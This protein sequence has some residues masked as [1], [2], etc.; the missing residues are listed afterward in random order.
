VKRPSLIFLLFVAAAWRLAAA[1]FHVSAAA[2]LTDALQE[3]AASYESKEGDKPVFNFGASSVLARQ[4]AE[5]APAD[6]FISADE[7]KMDQLE[8]KSLV[9]TGTRKSLL[10]NSLVIVVEQNSKLALNSPQDLTKLKRLALAETKTVPAGIYARKYLENLGLWKEVSGKI[11]P[12]ENVR[13]ALSAVESGNV[14][15]GIVYKTDAAISKTTKVAYE[16]PRKDLPEIS[17]AFAV[18]NTGKQS[19][20][21][22]RFL[23]YLASDKSLKV[24]EKYGFIINK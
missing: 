19:G 5:G 15:A 9:K 1:D 24:F 6:L 10:S 8:K 11:I 13:A 14:D 4:I 22:Q 3:L 18:M 7:E 16:V 21:A 12:T 23:N 17:Y 20:A 2:S